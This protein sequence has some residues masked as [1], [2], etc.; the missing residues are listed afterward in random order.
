VLED[1]VAAAADGDLV[2]LGGDVDY[3]DDAGAEDVGAED[4][5]D[6]VAEDEDVA[7]GCAG[8]EAEADDWLAG[9]GHVLL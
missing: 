8:S 2:D 7:E 1:A 9:E 4:A 3:L 6:G 5:V